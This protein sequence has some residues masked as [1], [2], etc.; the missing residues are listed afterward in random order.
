MD[1]LLLAAVAG[2]LF[3]AA[4]ARSCFG[5]G[6]ALVAMPLLV[7]LLGARTASPVV[8]LVTG[9]RSTG[10]A[11]AACWWPRCPGSRSAS[12]A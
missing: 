2:V 3:T 9:G 11:Q 6:D 4:V 8:A 1:P 7:A 5:F 12:S 10:P